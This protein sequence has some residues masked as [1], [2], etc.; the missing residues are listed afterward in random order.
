M[1]SRNFISASTLFVTVS[2]SLLTASTA[3]AAPAGWDAFVIRDAA[4]T[5]IEND[6]L[7]TV[8][9]IINISGKK[10]GLG[11]NLINGTKVGNIGTLSI[12]RLDA[13]AA[14]GSAYAPYMNIWVKDSL[15]N[16]AVIANEP[17]NPEWTG[18]SEWDT[19]GAN[20]ATKSIKLFE[21]SAGF[22]LPGTNIVRDS[23]SGALWFNS[24]NSTAVT[25]DAFADY[26]IE[27]PDTTYIAA[28]HPTGGAPRELGTNLA[29]G[30]NWIF[31]D[32]QGNYN[33]GSTTGYIVTNP[34]AT[35]V[36]EPAAIGMLGV[37]GLALLKRKRRAM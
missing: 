8:E 12:D 19:T 1:F 29:Y 26:I 14:G 7:G 32:T 31:G 21:I 9:Y 6:T 30:F 28:N 20:L 10:A 11:T 16:Y 27:A 18:T 36:P 25:F 5:V 3:Q 13:N 23:Q 33:S 37:A 17:S 2:G 22:T 24:L 34:V 4:T 15:G 35:A